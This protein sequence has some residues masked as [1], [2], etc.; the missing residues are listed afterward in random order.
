ML[1]ELVVVLAGASLIQGANFGT[2][3]NCQMVGNG[4]SACACTSDSCA[5]P[6]IQ[7]YRGNT[8]SCYVGILCPA[9]TINAGA[10]IIPDPPGAFDSE[11]SPISCWTGIYVNG[12][13][14]TATGALGLDNTCTSLPMDRQYMNITAHPLPISTRPISCWNGEYLNGQPVD[15][16][17][18]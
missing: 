13:P 6:S 2:V 1:L 16:P 17:R 14:V 3:N 10:Q 9:M 7:Q 5:D 11:D 4:I 12:V 15:K 18:G 8:L